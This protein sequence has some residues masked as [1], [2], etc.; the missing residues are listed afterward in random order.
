MLTNSSSVRLIYKI[1]VLNTLTGGKFNEE[2]F[3]FNEEQFGMPLAKMEWGK[4]KGGN[5]RIER[6]TSSTLRMNHTTRPIARGRHVAD[7]KP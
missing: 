6:R 7:W 1:K 5:R 3:G 2:K 4:S